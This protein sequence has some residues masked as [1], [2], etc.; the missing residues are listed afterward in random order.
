MNIKDLTDSWRSEAAV[1]RARGADLQARVLEGCVA[2]LVEYAER[3]QLEELT[4]S[5][6]ASESGFSEAHLR[7]LVSEGRLSNCGRKGIPRLR[8]G[9]LPRKA[10]RSTSHQEQGE[11]DLA[12]RVLRAR[13]LVDL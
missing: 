3:R 4:V 7:R 6:A 10:R 13:G 8:R 11:P 9:E 1:L 12:G 2:E 5:Q